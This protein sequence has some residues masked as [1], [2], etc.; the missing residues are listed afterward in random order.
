MRKT[1]IIALAALVSKS[2]LFLSVALCVAGCGRNDMNADIVGIVGLEEADMSDFDFKSLTSRVIELKS[3]IASLENPVKVVLWEDRMYVMNDNMETQNIL[4][5]SDEGDFITYLGTTGRGPGEYLGIS[6]FTVDSQ[7]NILIA[8]GVANKLIVYGSDLKYKT[9][10][11]FPFEIEGL[12]SIDGGYIVALAL[13]DKTYS[14]AGVITVSSEMSRKSTVL[15]HLE[16]YDENYELSTAKF[17][18]AEEG[19]F[20]NKAIDDNVYLL[21]STDGSILRQFYF[22]F[23]S[24]KVPD[25]IRQNID[26]S[27]ENGT[28]ENYMMLLNFAVAGARYA[29]GNMV[30]H[31]VYVDFI[32]DRQNSILYLKNVGED[33]DEMFVGYCGEELVSVLLPQE[34]NERFKLKFTT[35]P[36][37]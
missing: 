13:W 31:G 2:I 18:E 29:C 10:T 24:E 7:G 8:D 25:D 5:Y 33:M 11:D 36:L 19:Y 4:V 6:D 12:A 17:Q 26:A 22:D 9:V 30:R 3:D 27:M 20:Y 34:E 1:F 37:D 32:A 35:F 28:F 21:S 14:D 16:F 15:P 23:G